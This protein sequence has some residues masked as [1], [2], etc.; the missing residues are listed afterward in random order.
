MKLFALLLT[1]STMLLAETIL[2]TIDRKL[3]PVSAQMYKKLI[4]IEPDGSKKEFMMFQA[5]KDKD[6]MVSLFLSPDSEK[7][8]AT[9]RLGD[10]MW[11]YIPNVGRPLR[12][13]SMQSVVG[14]V[15]N[16]ADIMR[17]DFSTEYDV[18]T[19]EEKE[20]FILLTLKAKNDTVS[21]D[22]LVMQ[23]DKKTLTPMEVEC[24]TSTK[25]LIKTL[26]YKELKDFGDG[27]VRP[28]VVE[29]MS[30]MY[31]DYKSIMIYGKITPKNFPDEAFTLDTLANAS[32]LRR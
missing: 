2:E 12:I 16:N 25:M 5:K 4:N 10:N 9:L 7:G 20:D 14:G 28:S 17:L 31:K 6:K 8:R 30:P 29:T 13:T 23:V 32:D 1:L 27:I 26:Y 22:K 19:K 18:V 21:Y 11:L 24:Y 3:T 15:F